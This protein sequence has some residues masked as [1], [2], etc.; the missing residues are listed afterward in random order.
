LQTLVFDIILTKNLIFR[1]TA[2]YSN[3][4]TASTTFPTAPVKDSTSATLG[5]SF[6]QDCTSATTFHIPVSAPAQADLKALQDAVES[7]LLLRPMPTKRAPTL[8]LAVEALRRGE[9]PF[10]NPVR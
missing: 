5:S 3:P 1:L 2:L 7:T 4:M 6:A 8:R 10:L 9:T